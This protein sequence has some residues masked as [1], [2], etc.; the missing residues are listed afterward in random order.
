M[1]PS[2]PAVFLS[3]NF[4]VPFASL[5]LNYFHISLPQH[6]GSYAKVSYVL[7]FLCIPS[8]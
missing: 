1:I 3:H 7:D 6:I 8:F 4:I 5:H 2:L